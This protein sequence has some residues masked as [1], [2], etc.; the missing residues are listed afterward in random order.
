MADRKIG[1]TGFGNMGGG[2]A[3][4]LVASGYDVVVYDLRAEAAQAASGQLTLMIGGDA[5]DVEA[6]N[7]ARDTLGSRQIYYGG[8]GAG[9]ATKIVDNLVSRSVAT[10]LGEA[11][12][13]DV[14]A[15]LAAEILR[16]AMNNTAASALRGQ[17]AVKAA[18]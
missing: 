11:V 13:M 14:A 7:D 6:R 2:M 18:D 8:P 9:V 1:Y 16:D 4:H 3:A 17:T 10:P 15:G 5:N 12:A